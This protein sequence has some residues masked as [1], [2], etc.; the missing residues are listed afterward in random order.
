[1]TRSVLPSHTPK[2]HDGLEV[3]RLRFQIIHVLRHTTDTMKSSETAGKY[4]ATR[5]NCEGHEEGSLGRSALRAT[6]PQRP[7]CCQTQTFDPTF[8]IG[9]HWPKVVIARTSASKR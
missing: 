3:T 7:G 6:G 8:Q 1:M 5:S 9:I 2:S 4:A